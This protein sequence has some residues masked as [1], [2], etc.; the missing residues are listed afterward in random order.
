MLSV[1]VLMKTCF[2]NSAILKKQSLVKNCHVRVFILL[3]VFCDKLT[4]VA[5][6]KL[7]QQVLAICKH[8]GTDIVV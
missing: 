2:I 1:K 3:D 7:S 5:F 6:F 4:V 8:T